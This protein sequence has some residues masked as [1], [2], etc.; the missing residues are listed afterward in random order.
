M[1][2]STSISEIPDAL[3]PATKLREYIGPAALQAIIDLEVGVASEPVRSGIGYL[4]LRATERE[5]VRVP[6]FET[7]EPQI[8]AEWRRRA[9]D[10]ALRDYLDELRS[11]AVIVMTVSP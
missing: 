2:S 7:F 1:P 8:H 11:R 6:E 4:I 5:P 3:L 9:G 10:D